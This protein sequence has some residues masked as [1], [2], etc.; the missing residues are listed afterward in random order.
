MA[1]RTTDLPQITKP[2]KK[3][4]TVE[5][6][7]KLDEEPPYSELVDGVRVRMP[8]STHNHWQIIFN[9]VSTLNPY[10]SAQNLGR[11][12]GEVN[13]IIEGI[14]GANGWIPD[15]VF[16]SKDNS[17]EIKANW[18]GR[19]DWV[20]EVWA[21]TAQKPAR[22]T[23]KRLRWQR[24][25]VPELWEIIIGKNEQI[26][27]VYNL[28]E[29]NVYRETQIKLNDEKVCSQVITGF[30]ITRSEIFANLVEE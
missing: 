23:E 12:G 26:V 22:I 28:D 24:A 18:L 19:P 20:L 29:Q 16:A 8:N 5:E 6:W 13:V 27:K 11:V 30:C 14:T 15:A 3:L 2:R 1:L 7:L 25:A 10:V 9:V 21:A 17:I 4:Y